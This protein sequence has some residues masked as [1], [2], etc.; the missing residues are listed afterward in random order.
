MSETHEFQAETRQLLDLMIHS[1]YSHKEIFLR[2]LVSNASDALD[3]LRFEGLTDTSLLPEAELAIELRV[4]PEARTLSIRDNGIGMSRDEV[5]AQIG[6]IARSGTAEFLKQLGDRNEGDAAVDLIG[7]FGVGFYSSFM[8]ADRVTLT[9]QRAGQG[10][11]TTWESAADGRYTLE[12][13]DSPDEIAGGSGTTV[14]LHLKPVDGED[15]LADFTDEWVLRD[16]VKRYSDFVAY[17]IRLHVEG[18]DEQQ[19]EPLNSMKAIWTRPADDV[20]EDE[21]TEFYRH[22]SHD[23][24]DPL[25]RIPARIEG[26]FEARALLYVPSAAPHDLYHRERAHRGVQL[27]VKRVFIMD[28]C[29]DL[30]PEYLRFVRGVVD[31]EDLSLNVSREILQQDAQIRVIRNHLTKKVTEALAQM[32]GEMKGDREGDTGDDRYLRFW[33]E[34]GPV[35]KEGLLDFAEKKERI[36][37]LMLCAST[38]H[39]SRLTSLA[40]YVE[41]MSDDQDVIYYLC[42]PS[43]EVLAASPQLEA[44]RSRG[45]EVLLFTDPV[46]DVWLQQMPPEYAGKKFQSAAQGALELGSEEERKEAAEQTEAQQSD[47]K[48]LLE[49]LRA[50]IQDDVKEVRLSQRLTESPSCLVLDEGDLSP[51]IEEMLRQAGQDVPR[52]LPILELNPKHPLLLKLKEMHEQDA[53]NA[54]LATSAELLLGQAILAGG[55]QLDDPAAFSRKVADLMEAAL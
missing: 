48:G 23:Q 12:S 51:Q 55:G 46:D 28:E 17:P 26:N 11:V 52:A 37:D 4:D 20:G 7:Q 44:F 19:D 21:Y 6:T 50:A 31:A 38:D 30:I 39:E 53:T 27:Y 18:R 47:F 2:E 43:R 10:A 16:V 41:R 54:R 15:G 29:R 1:L 36:L 13:G 3:R 49:S 40:D 35:L 42:G 24:Q 34:F 33:A 32:K 5:I 25:L 8:A 14:I 22:I 9:T 45:V